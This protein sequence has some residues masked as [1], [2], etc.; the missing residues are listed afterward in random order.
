[1]SGSCDVVLAGAAI[2]D[3]PVVP[4]DE[5]VFTRGSTPAERIILTSGGDAMNEAIVLSRLGR[6]V[7]LISRIGRDAAGAYLKDTCANAGMDTQYLYEIDQLDTGVNVVLVGHDGERRFLTNPH[8][9]LR[10]LEAADIVPEALDHAK[11]FCFASI[12]VFP[13][14]SPQ[15]L[16]QIFHMARSRGVLVCADM[17]S[18]KNNETIADLAPALRQLDYFFANQEEAQQITGL[19]DPDAIA[20]VLLQTGVRH[21]IIKRGAHGCLIADQT[22]TQHIPACP[23]TQC[24]DT[25]G[26][27]DNFAAG[28]L[29]ALLDGR[30]FADCARYANACAAISVEAVGASAG[31]T[32]AA[33]VQRRYQAA[34]QTTV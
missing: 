24:I 27:G 23:D 1:M 20:Q 12:F 30:S 13:R 4:V 9:S 16:E 31:V 32:D 8:G 3:V 17:T 33:Q 28:F 29:S 34:Y 19:S 11:I 7:R 15:Q 21:V 25:T 22:G 26:A 14:I 5:S 6:K 18:P 2:I 10:A